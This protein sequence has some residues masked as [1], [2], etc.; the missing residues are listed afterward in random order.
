MQ[1][2]PIRKIFVCEFI[3]GGGLNHSELNSSLVSEGLLMRDALLKD[4]AL[5]PYELLITIDARLIAPQVK[6]QITYIQAN[7][8]VWAIWDT[9]MTQVDAAWMIA[10]ETD[11]YLQKLTSIALK[12]Q[13]IILGCGL[14]TIAICRS[15]LATYHLF[16]QHKLNTVHTFLSTNWD[17]T[18]SNKWVVKPDD[19]AGCEDTLV[20]NDTDLLMDWIIRYHKTQTHIIQPYIEGSPASISCIMHKGSAILLSCNAQLISIKNNVFS[21]D[22]FKVNGMQAHWALFSSLASDIAKLLPDASGYVGIDLMICD[23]G[24]DQPEVSILEVNPRLTTTYAALREATGLNPAK[25][26]IDTLT[27]VNDESCQ[28]ERNEV[29]LKVGHA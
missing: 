9:L 1:N 10:P 20:F 18:L 6:T 25:L 2:K 15:K 27:E 29:L 8:D 7:E 16:Q 14:A 13:K 26:I 28:I 24:E 11:G 5:L 22:G 23:I 19:G 12:H 3:T 21:Y 4:L 17:K